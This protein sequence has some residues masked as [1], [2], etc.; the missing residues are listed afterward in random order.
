MP[1]KKDGFY[2]IIEL[3]ITNHPT[4][5]LG[6]IFIRNLLIFLYVCRGHVDVDALKLI[7]RDI[8]ALEPGSHW[9]VNGSQGSVERQMGV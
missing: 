4:T 9:N 8:A 2:L 7:I 3:S 5:S 6:K 1:D